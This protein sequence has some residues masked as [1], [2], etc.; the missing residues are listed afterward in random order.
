MS[1]IAFRRQRDRVIIKCI[2][3]HGTCMHNL[4]ARSHQRPD[5]PPLSLALEKWTD[6][7]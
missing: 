5:Q 7:Q 2:N 1:D 4:K 6:R 3:R